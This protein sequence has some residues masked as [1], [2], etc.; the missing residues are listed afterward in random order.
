MSVPLME[1]VDPLFLKEKTGKLDK[2]DRLDVALSTRASE[3]TL[4][5]L[6]GKFPSAQALGDALSNPT[7]TLIGSALLGWDSAGGVWERIKTDGSGR[8]LIWLG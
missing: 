2:L 4:S 3:S 1:I 6:S 7:T 5:S 8:L